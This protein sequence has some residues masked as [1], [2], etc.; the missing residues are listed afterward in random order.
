MLHKF[1]FLSESPKNFIFQKSS[2]ETNFG[3]FFCILYIFIT[4]FIIIY[5]FIDFFYLS[6]KY[7]IEYS[8]MY[9]L[10]TFDN[11][12]KINEK[13]ADKNPLLN[14]S[15]SLY[16][17]EP[18]FPELSDRFLLV[19][20]KNSQDHLAFIKRN[21]K[22][23]TRVSDLMVAIVYNCS[24]SNCIING[25][26]ETEISYILRIEYDSYEIN[27][28]NTYNPF[29]KHRIS[30]I[31][32]FYFNNL[33]MVSLNWENIIYKQN[34]KGIDLLR[35]LE[36]N[37]TI[38]YIVSHSSFP[39]NKVDNIQK[40]DDGY[41]VKG[42]GLFLMDNSHSKEIEYTRTGRNEID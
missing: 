32:P 12:N 4:L 10:Q 35:D 18:N 25:E 16:K 39:P 24:D 27:H 8:F 36:K 5:S 2:N 23:E 17:N 6:E 33:I 40:T 14:F 20:P 41:Y 26:D 34:I 7:S 15:L 42:L 1:D 28:Q 31:V 21:A 11:I 38:G 37:K 9:N 19:D 30:Y 29:I 13:D 3:G 22:I